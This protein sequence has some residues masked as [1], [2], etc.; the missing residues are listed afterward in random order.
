M[1]TPAGHLKASRTNVGTPLEPFR[2][3]RTPA[4]L[5]CKNLLLKLQLFDWWAHKGSHFV[6]ESI[7]WGKGEGIRCL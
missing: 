5:R 7:A 3:L 1:F 4:E 6:N 2:S